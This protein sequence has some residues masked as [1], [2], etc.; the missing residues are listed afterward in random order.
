MNGTEVGW[1]V[2]FAWGAAKFI[3]FLK[4]TRWFPWLSAQTETANRVFAM[5][6]ALL[7]AVGIHFK[8]DPEAGTLLIDGLTYAG[9][10][11]GIQE[12]LKQWMLQE[13]AYQKLIKENNS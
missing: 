8:F 11:T 10:T 12:Y 7:V 4:W 13:V 1:S 2:V 9:I 5:V 6:M 3:Q